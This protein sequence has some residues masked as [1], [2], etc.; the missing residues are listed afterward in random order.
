MKILTELEQLEKQLKELKNSCEFLE[1]EISETEK[2]I[3]KREGNF[4]MSKGKTRVYKFYK[5]KKKNVLILLYDYKYSVIMKRI[6]ELK[7][8][9]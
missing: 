3:S 6:E 4:L 2:I 7:Q 1:H 8:P 9:K 5:E